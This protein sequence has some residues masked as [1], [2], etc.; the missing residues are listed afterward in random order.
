MKIQDKEKYYKIA[1]D[2]QGTFSKYSV[3]H[4]NFQ[5]TLIEQYSVLVWYLESL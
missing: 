4:T 2:N 3:G 1:N 5:P